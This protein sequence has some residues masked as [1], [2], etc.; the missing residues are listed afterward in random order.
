MGFVVSLD[1]NDELQTV[2]MDKQ[3]Q[4]LEINHQSDD[5]KYAVKL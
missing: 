5:F 2:H 4:G 1:A 3:I